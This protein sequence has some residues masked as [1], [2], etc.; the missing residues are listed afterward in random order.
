MSSPSPLS[1]RAGDLG[2]LFE[3]ALTIDVI[4]TIGTVLLGFFNAPWDAAVFVSCILELS[5]LLLYNSFLSFRCSRLSGATSGIN[6]LSSPGWSLIPPTKT[7]LGLQMLFLLSS[8]RF[9]SSA[10]G[11]SPLLVHWL[12]PPICSCL[13]CCHS[14]LLSQR[15]F[16]R[17]A[18]LSLADLSLTLLL[19]QEPCCLS[20]L[21]LNLFKLL[22]Q[23]HKGPLLFQPQC[24]RFFWFVKPVIR[25]ERLTLGEV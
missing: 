10:I 9:C 18:L 12:K 5:D 8:S 13:L 14:L 16:C 6:V 7:M 17:F 2:K 21:S 15:F 20:F 19:S 1:L 24:L 25:Q 11:G 4:S 22:L 3:R 23:P